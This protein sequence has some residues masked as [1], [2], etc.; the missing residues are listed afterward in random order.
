MCARA[1]A[2]VGGAQTLP[3]ARYPSHPLAPHARPSAFRDHW[4]P[5]KPRS[6]A[7]GRCFLPES[8]PRPSPSGRMTSLQGQS[9]IPDAP[10]TTSLLLHRGPGDTPCHANPHEAVKTTTH[11]PV[12]HGRPRAIRFVELPDLYAV[13][14]GAGR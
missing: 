4:P 13:V 1:S 10:T 6:A 14:E 11:L 3:R 9:Q 5:W 7:V 2:Q 12:C 8:L